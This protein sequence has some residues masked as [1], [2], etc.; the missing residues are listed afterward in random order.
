MSDRLK[1]GLAPTIQSEPD[2]SW[3]C[4]FREVVDNGELTTYMKSQKIL[5]TGFKDKGK[6]FMQKIRK[7]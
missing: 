2:F 6:N 4:T 7:N 3:I 1:K 5:I